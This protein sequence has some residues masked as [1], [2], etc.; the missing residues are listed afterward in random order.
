MNRAPLGQGLYF[1]ATGLWPLVHMK[2]FE[3]VSGPK[4]DRWLVKTF[5]S[6]IAVVGTS[7]IAGALERTPSRAVRLLGIGSAAALGLAELVFVARGRISRVYLADSLVELGLVASWLM[8][9]AG[10]GREP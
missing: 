8:H 5:G 10:A 1:I 4:V 9:S 7:L 6:L 2:S 3:A